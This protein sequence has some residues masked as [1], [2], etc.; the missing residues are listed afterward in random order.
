MQDILLA[1]IAGLIVG[2]LFAWIK[3]PIPAPPALPGIMGIVG[4][5]MGFKLF[6]WVSV[7][8]FG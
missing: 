7:S 6:Q 2:F 1:I 5:Y 4:I 3:L 8:F